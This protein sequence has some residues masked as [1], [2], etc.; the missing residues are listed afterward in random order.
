ML[1]VMAL[2]TTS[3]SDTA[4]EIKSLVF[5]R[6]FAPLN[7]EAA[8]VKETSAN[9]SWDASAGATHYI[10]EVYADDS[11]TFAGTP[12]Q[13][14]KNLTKEDIPY[15]V[16]NLLFDTPYSVRV[17]AVTEGN[18]SRTSTW[19]GAYFKTGTKQFMSNP[20][21]A[22]ISD[23]SVTI[24]W[25]VEEGFDV[26][27]IVVGNV[28]HTITAEEKEAGKA[29]VEGLSPETQYTAY[30]YYNGKQ[31]GNRNFTTIAD[32]QGAILVHA[33]D[34]LKNLIEEAQGGEVFALY[35]G[36]YELNVN[37]EGKTG[38]VK[39]SNTITIKGIYPTD[40]PVVKGRFE[41]YDGAG[42]SLSQ[43][44]IDGS[45]N[46][47]ADQLFNYKTADVTYAPLD[48]QN[49]DINGQ[50]SGKGLVYLNVKAIVEGIT[51]NNS[52][53]HGIQCAGGDFIDSRAG[54][55]RTI[56]LSNSTFYDCAGNRDFIRIDDASANF[57]GETGPQIVIDH[58]TFNNVGGAATN[59]RL[60]YVRF[61]GN[62]ITFTNN[63][64]VGTN[65][66][67]GFSNQTST[68]AE[69]TLKGN[70]YFNC[71]NLTGAGAGADAKIVW[72][73]ESGII[74]DPGFANPAAAD[75]TLN[76]DSEAFKAAA[77]DPRWLK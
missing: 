59:Y 28:T 56:T 42:L 12:V 31:C 36:T 3:C 40:Q 24:S 67:R 75:F 32:L 18:D 5:G 34:N 50:E 72:F 52:I 21:P 43:L 15:T 30:L 76:H 58:C 53:V 10:M 63:V 27:T 9:I 57:A 26:T 16:S 1:G 23:R 37:D 54:L 14:I 73:D 70:F 45:N 62:K 64:V 8:N 38:A 33:G 22:D 25:E 69:P 35:G 49:C 66:K 68:D 17:Q 11:L 51:F 2:T 44:K 46:S 77:G 41:L 60:L 74:G 19:N 55:P 47:T 39:V 13:V 6:N 4:D 61:A 48:I 7:I 65:Y 20:K 71:E 29:T